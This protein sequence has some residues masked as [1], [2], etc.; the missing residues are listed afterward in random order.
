M[1]KKVYLGQIPNDFNLEKD[2]AFSPMSFVGKENLIEGWE[3]IKFDDDPFENLKLCSK[4]ELLCQRE[5][6]YLLD[7]FSTKF[8]KK[9]NL[10]YSHNFWK[11]ILFPWIP[12]VVSFAY[13]KQL[14]VENFI[15]KN[16]NEYYHILLIKDNINWNFENC[17]D[18]MQRGL[19][20]SIFNEWILSRFFESNL[21]KKWTCEYIDKSN[22]VEKYKNPQKKFTRFFPFL[23]FLNGF[24][25]VFEVYGFRLVD[26]IIFNLLIYF[27][28]PSKK[29]D[30]FIDVSNPIKTINWLY[31][32][33]KLFEKTETKFI[34]N[35]TENLTKHKRIR[36]TKNKINLISAAQITNT[37]NDLK[38]K[39]A[40]KKEF[41]EKLFL[42]Q[43]GGH[44][45]GT[46][47]YN[48]PASLVEYNQNTFITWGWEEQENYRGN[49]VNLPS[50][51]L[52]SFIDKHNSNNEKI[53]LVGNYMNPFFYTFQ[54]YPTSNQIVKYRKN[55][56][57]FLKNLKKSLFNNIDY[58]PYKES[59]FSYKDSSYIKSFFSEINILDGDLH[60]KMLKCRLLVLD[61]P[62]T[63]LLIALAAN[64]PLICFWEKNHF[65]FSN[66]SSTLY[67]EL[68]DNN[69]FFNSPYDASNFLNKLKNIEQ[70][71]NQKKIQNLRLRFLNM[72]GNLNKKWRKVWINY[73][74]NININERKK[75]T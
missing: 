40:L 71:W 47:K 14:R 7:L 69:I 66:Q 42:V 27:N 70:W 25:R 9:Y 11:I 22:K 44:N 74:K 38:I 49:F 12:Y 53:I 56:I 48:S 31:S 35:I 64:V 50:P 32:I 20:N 57:K 21:P 60:K 10:N 75:Y 1:I 15:K 68:I 54:G 16:K 46:S 8:N 55:K 62:G 58:R 65:P 13:E 67:N 37:D 30:E 18:L 72:H 51:Y 61:H 6:F 41:G 39:F 45:Y 29:C 23:K 26:F 33:E 43:H 63:T 34:K 52:S 73:L 17:L 4:A 5:S 2:I 36:Y 59:S 19:K 24:Y 3:K 28:K